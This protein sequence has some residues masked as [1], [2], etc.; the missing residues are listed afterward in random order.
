M[1]MSGFLY[2]TRHWEVDRIRLA[3]SLDYLVE[4]GRRTQILIFPEGTDLSQSNI[5]KSNKFADAHNLPK[6]SYTLHPKTT[7]FSYLTRHLQV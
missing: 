2:I 3:E 7:G 4:L 1:Q 5:V 6:H